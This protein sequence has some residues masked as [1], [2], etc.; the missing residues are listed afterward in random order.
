MVANRAQSAIEFLMTYSYV[1][2][3]IAIAMSV[4]LLYFSLP[5]TV[6]PFECNFYS[7][8][9][10]VDAALI[11]NTNGASLIVVG[12][13]NQPGIT[14]IS[15][16][17]AFVNYKSSYYSTCTPSVAVAGQYVYCIA[18]FSFTPL[19]TNVYYGTFNMS[20]NYCANLP[21]NLSVASCPSSNTFKYS[22]SI[23]VQATRQTPSTINIG[24]IAARSAVVQYY[25]PIKI[26]NSQ[27]ATQVPFQQLLEVPTSTYSSYLSNSLSNVEFSTL[28]AMHGTV[29]QA[30]IENNA[31]N[32]AATTPIWVYL[33]SGIPA[34][35]TVTIYMNFLNKSK[36]A[37][38]SS[39]PTGAWAGYAQQQN[40]MLLYQPGTDNGNVIFP[41]Y[42]DF[43][44]SVLNSA[45]WTS[46]G[47]V[48]VS[49]GIIIP[50]SATLG[51][52]E[53]VKT[54]NAINNTIDISLTVRVPSSGGTMSLG[55]NALSTPVRQALYWK[56]TN[57]VGT[58][59]VTSSASGSSGTN[60]GPSSSNYIFSMWSTSN[61]AYFQYATSA[62]QTSPTTY[63]STTNV[64]TGSSNIYLV[65]NNGGASGTSLVVNYVLVRASPPAG[66]MPTATFGTVTRVN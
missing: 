57:P 55:Y 49:N 2:L 29:L 46:S 53:S 32:T 61:T 50:S 35:S 18:N 12:I 11:N 45:L 3:I 65:N 51:Y 56:S 15:T 9:T 41:F 13:D 66:V 36:S 7:G 26:T 63:S 14:N 40:S 5:K 23:R 44:G 59:G 58:S 16:F 6:I 4:L 27:A 19:Y 60:L 39:G 38:S 42:D 17:S 20:A 64:Y 1:F 30:W 48:T 43:P 62:L 10:C 21:Q 37:L 33:P 31:I 24:T 25:V 52:A 8:F 54:F 34:N 22:G 28:P 47:T